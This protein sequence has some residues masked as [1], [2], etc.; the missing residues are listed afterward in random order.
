MPSRL[1]AAVFALILSSATVDAGTRSDAITSRIGAG[2]ETVG[3]SGYT[4]AGDLGAATY[5]RDV[6]LKA[7]GFQS[8]DGAFWSLAEVTINIAMCGAIP[9]DGIDD[10]VAIR[11]AMSLSTGKTLFIP[12]GEWNICATSGTEVLLWDQQMQI[13]GDGKD[14]SIL[15]VCAATPATIDAVRANP[16]A[17]AIKIGWSIRNLS[18]LPETAGLTARHGFH[19]DLDDLAGEILSH[20]TMYNVNIGEFR[21]RAFSMNKGGEGFAAVTVTIASPGVVSWAA[22]GF[23]ADQ[24][25]RIKTSGALPTGLTANTTYYVRNPTANT[26]ELSAT[27][28]GASINTSGTQSGTHTGYADPTNPDG[29]FL[30]RVTDSSFTGGPQADA[31]VFLDN[32]GDSLY[33]AR[34]LGYG[35]TTTGVGIHTRPVAGAAQ[36]VFEDWNITTA[37]GAV[38]IIDGLQVKIIRGQLEQAFAFTGPTVSGGLGCM[39]RLRGTTQQTEILGI[40]AN[41]QGRVHNICFEDSAA[42]NTVRDS[43]LTGVTTAAGNKHFIYGA[44]TSENKEQNNSL[45]FDGVPGSGPKVTNSST[46]SQ[47]YGL[48]TVGDAA[49]VILNTDKVV[50]TSVALTSPRNWTLPPASSMKASDRIL[51]QDPVVVLKRV[52]SNVNVVR[53][54]S[55]TINGVTSFAL[56]WPGASVEFVTDGVSTW[57]T[58]PRL[59]GVRFMTDAD[60]TILA[61]DRSL[62][63][64]SAF[65][66]ARTKT[67]PA[68]NTFPMGTQLVFFDAAGTLTQ[69]NTITFARAGSDTFSDG[70][71]SVILR[72]PLSTLIL[73]S[74]GNTIWEVIIL[75]EQ[76]SYTPILTG[77]TNVAASTA[78][79]TYYHRSAGNRPAESVT[80]WGQVSVDPTAAALTKLG[81]SLPTPSNLTTA[82]QCGGMAGAT[83]VNQ[84][85]PI[86]GDA[87]NDRAELDFTAT[88]IANQPMQFQ[89]TCM[90]Q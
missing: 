8:A 35:P 61:T 28:G 25:V 33:F 89:F 2:V 31:D 1:V 59:T 20:F 38:D 73:H 52:T 19:I 17:G 63:T 14:S 64:S 13:E 78:N 34:N 15:R 57:T 36:Q 39:I 48:K 80:V 41:A 49:Y 90:V 72:A 7:C 6:S 42:R 4:T 77:V 55:D 47:P 65:T 29:F 16:A 32:S 10:T 54:G 43:M 9:D 62:K 84:N 18:I 27:A 82:F 45:Y 53:S 22:H 75:D 85:G 68:A 40:N 74:N 69:T 56:N 21:K 83:A 60:E 81:I 67:L 51:I 66:S 70:S 86:I 12:K 79:T 71:T 87:T 44:S 11:A 3:T 30:S 50:Q 58:D 88:D 23:A 46:V 5:K 76:G 24:K 26:F 37:A